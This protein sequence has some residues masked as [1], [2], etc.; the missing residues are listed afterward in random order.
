MVTFDHVGH[1]YAVS[2]HDVPSVTQRI[3]AA[4][5]LG[6][7]VSFYSSAAAERGTRVHLACLDLDLK[8]TVTLPDD[9]R[10]YLDS[11]SQ[12]CTMI[13][14]TWTLL[15]QPHYS[16]AYDTAGTADRI[17][18]IGG[19]PVVLDLKTGGLAPWHGLQLAMYDLLHGDVPAQQRRRIA[20]SLRKD[21]RLAQS[22]EFHAA[23]D[24]IHALELMK[25]TVKNGE[26]SPDHDHAGPRP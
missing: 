9:E 3:E 2:G 1:R 22:V 14:P 8:R 23:A 11:Y 17:G 4:G 6:P 21:G 12:W 15:E 7:A 5:L 16:A 20:L 18:T 13:A 25:R 10:G 19:A 26:D 24:Y